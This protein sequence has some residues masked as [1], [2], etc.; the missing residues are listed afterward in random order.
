MKDAPVFDQPPNRGVRPL[1]HRAPA[2]LKLGVALALAAGTAVVPV[3]WLWWHAAVAA[4][5]LTIVFMAKIRWRPLGARLLW[6]SPFVAGAALASALQGPAGPGWRAVALRGS[7]CL[8]TMLLL[9]AT[10]SFSALLVVLHRIRVPAL[11]VTTLALM[12]RYLHLLSDEAQ[13]MNRA[14][15]CRTFTPSRRRTWLISGEVIGRLFVRAS[16]RAERIYLA[17]AARGWS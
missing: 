12:Y 16:E 4:L 5:L 8:L 11:L 3:T 15:A 7:L 9:G 2:G 1:I 6:F 17:M 13:R 10:T 14:R